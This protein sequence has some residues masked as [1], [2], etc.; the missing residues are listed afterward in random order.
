MV[1]A[2]MVPTHAWWTIV[3]IPKPNVATNL[4]IACFDTWSRYN[5]GIGS[6]NTTTSSSTS[7]IP[8]DM[9]AAVALPQC[10]SDVIEQDK[11]HIYINR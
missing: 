10:P 6:E 4:Y 5:I 7:R 1:V 9:N 8:R 11:Q 2:Q 3:K